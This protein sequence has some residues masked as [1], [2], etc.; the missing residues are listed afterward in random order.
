MVPHRSGQGGM[1][2]GK[3]GGK[4]EGTK[5]GGSKEDDGGC[6]SVYKCLLLLYEQNTVWPL[7]GG[8]HRWAEQTK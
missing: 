8:K 1:R 6:P 5:E 2:E 7:P 3:K 4:K